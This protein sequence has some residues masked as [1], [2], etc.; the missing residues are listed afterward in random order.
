[1]AAK[2]KVLVVDPDLVTQKLVAETLAARGGE[3][4]CLRSSQEAVAVIEREKFDGV[5]L[6][7]LLPG[8]DGLELARQIRRSKS[9]YHTPVI[10]VSDPTH[11]RLLSESFAAGVNLFL[12]KPV[13]HSKLSR[14]LNA[15]ERLMLEERRDYQRAA[16]AIPIE[17]QH[18]EQR[19]T[20]TSVNLSARGM[21][22][23]LL[24]PFPKG[25][26]IALSF[27]LPG[28]RDKFQVKGQVVR[29]GPDQAVGIKF[30][31]LSPAQR[32]SLADF[33]E[34]TQKAVSATLA[35]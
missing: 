2:H 28:R 17:C 15:V 16:L 31:R 11:P 7:R 26:D 29:I 5:I 25:C 21:L 22:L 30:T 9:N 19:T 32:T 33:I 4:K 24:Q 20:G 34:Q 8:I 12:T 18:G 27:T 13:T 6:T 3:A 10:F 1:M 23:K 35:R 14:A